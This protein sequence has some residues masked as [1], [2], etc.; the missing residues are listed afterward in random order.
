MKFYKG[1]KNNQDYRVS[2]GD[3]KRK[4]GTREWFE[5]MFEDDE[6]DSDRWGHQWRASQKFRYDCSLELLKKFLSRESAIQILDIGCGIGDFAEKVKH[7]FP[8]VTIVGADVSTNAILRASK[9][10]P[11]FAYMVASLPYIPIREQTFRL[12]ICLEVL[13][14]LGQEN[15]KES[16]ERILHCLEPDS[17]LLL[18]VVLDGG[19]SYFAENDL[20]ELVSKNFRLVEE[21]YTYSRIYDSVEKKLLRLQSIC[22]AVIWITRMQNERY[23]EWMLKKK[24]AFGNNKVYFPSVIRLS[25]PAGN[26]WLDP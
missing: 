13:Y 15:R 3:Q 25:L 12:I 19:K 6:S 2:D 5:F 17:Y 23:D 11:E 8:S 21:R 24:N 16:L 4:W 22:Q 1:Y 20:K 26:N 9:R 10:A 18:S 14:Y 7:N